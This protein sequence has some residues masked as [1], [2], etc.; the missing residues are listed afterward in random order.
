MSLHTQSAKASPRTGLRVLC[1]LPRMKDSRIARR[2]DMLK[3][4]GYAVEAVAFEREQDVGRSPD[5]PV[6]SLGRIRHGHYIERVSKMARVLGTIRRAARRSD[7]LYAF[8]C[9]L[10]FLSMLASSGFRLPVVMETADI[11][12]IQVAR[13]WKGRAVRLFEKV[14]VD[15]SDLLVITAPGYRRYYRDWVKSSKHALVIEN[16]LDRSFAESIRENIMESTR[17]HTTAKGQICIGWFG[18]L[19]HEWSW[20]V[21]K[22]LIERYPGRYVA[23]LAGVGM[24]TDFSGRVLSHPGVRYL[25]EYQHPQGLSN[26][27]ASVDLVMACYPVTVPGSWSRSN[28]YHEACL[29]GKP[30][31][32]RTGCADSEPVRRHEIGLVIRS[33]DPDE[34]ADEIASA[35]LAQLSRWRSRMRSLPLEEYSI[36][37]EANLLGEALCLAV[38]NRR[39]RLLGSDEPYRPGE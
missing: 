33:S 2:V 28:R 23:V 30:L 12:T 16:K 4:A 18:M 17:D 6:V 5:C 11:R 26:L 20:S 7:I 32:V 29:Y 8:N 10:A 24:L 31:V 19:R 3:E 22:R 27:Y 34:A 35:T 13:S 36:T 37:D 1:L 9:D 39:L 25:G 14:V 21:L 15:R 38:H